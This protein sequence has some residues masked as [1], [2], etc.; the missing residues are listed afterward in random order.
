MTR[1]STYLGE[2]GCWKFCNYLCNFTDCVLLFVLSF[3]IIILH[4]ILYIVFLSSFSVFLFFYSDYNYFIHY[5]L[6]LIVNLREK[7]LFSPFFSLSWCSQQVVSFFQ[8]ADLLKIT[9]IK[10]VEHYIKGKTPKTC[11]EA[12]GLPGDTIFS[13]GI[14][15]F[16]RN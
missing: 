2:V 6:D 5:L 8:C 7:S 11:L 12:L 1:L 16:I 14:Y 9:Q 3:F 10:F 15:L 13:L 4:F